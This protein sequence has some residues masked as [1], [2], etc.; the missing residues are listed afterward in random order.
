MPE[1]DGTGYPPGSLGEAR[2]QAI[3]RLKDW[4][5]QVESR[6]WVW[7]TAFAYQLWKARQMLRELEKPIVTEENLRQAIEAIR[8]ETHAT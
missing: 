6:G 2:E 1:Y 8:K 3:E 5:R 7:R 4:I